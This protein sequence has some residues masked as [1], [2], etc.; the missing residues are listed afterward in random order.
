MAAEGEIESS[1]WMNLKLEVFEAKL[2]KTTARQTVVMIEHRKRIKMRN[3]R[4]I[5]KRPSPYPL[6]RA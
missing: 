6:K 4:K 2:R 1:P 3:F 5:V